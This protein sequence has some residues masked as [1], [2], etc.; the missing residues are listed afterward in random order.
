MT[1]A[2]IE[3]VKYGVPATSLKECIHDIEVLGS[4]LIGTKCP[5]CGGT[6]F[7]K[8]GSVKHK[9]QKLPL[10]ICQDC[11][12]AFTVNGDI[13]K[14][15]T[16]VRASR[17]LN[18]DNKKVDKLLY[19]MQAF[20]LVKE[21]APET[22]SKTDF[23]ARALKGNLKRSESYNNIP[24]YRHL[25]ENTGFE[26]KRQKFEDALRTFP[27]GDLSGIS[28]VKR[29]VLWRRYQEIA[30]E[31]FVCEKTCAFSRTCKKDH[32]ERKECSTVKKA[33]KPKR[34][35]KVDIVI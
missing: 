23:G 20:G 2:R 26:L 34:V 35:W 25:I 27:E 14:P 22:Y 3:L 17:Y 21:I 11:G 13:T 5:K 33:L 31:I 28:K 19:D 4:A 18:F 1:E 32:R 10:R 30:I 6:D 7:W 12:Y 24:I 16:Q 8:R 15:F 9:D 29:D